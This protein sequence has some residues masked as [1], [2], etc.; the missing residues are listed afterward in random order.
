MSLVS[1]EECWI[2]ILSDT[3]GCKCGKRPSRH[4]DGVA[5]LGLAPSYPKMGQDFSLHISLVSKTGRRVLDHE[6]PGDISTWLPAASSDAD[7]PIYSVSATIPF[8]FFLWSGDYYVGVSIV[9]RRTGL[10]LQL[11]FGGPDKNGINI[12]FPVRIIR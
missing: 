11:A 8:P 9:D 5:N 12:L 1:Y 6:I 7:L 4:P 10:P 2:R 3:A